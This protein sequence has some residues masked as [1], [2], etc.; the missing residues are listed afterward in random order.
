MKDEFVR[1]V[2]A[3]VAKHEMLNTG[4]KVVVAVSGGVDS[5]A[6]LYYLMERKERKDLFIVVAHVDH[7]FRGEES[8]QDLLYVRSIC[9]QLQVPFESARIPVAA[10]Q[11]EH[12]LGAQTA[13]REC[14]YRFLEEVMNKY[15]ANAL[16]LGHHGDDQVETILMRLVRGS[17]MKGYAGMSV[18]R[19]FS[20]GM[21][22][23]PFF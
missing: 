14:R 7:M 6:L 19:A 11:K 23:R 12:H 18:K 5:L 15:K 4:E 9:E 3:F 13:A 17:S 16:A 20:H 21:I 22:I 2:D 8:W 1:K 10:Y